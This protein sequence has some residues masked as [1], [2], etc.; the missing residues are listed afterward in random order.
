VFRHVLAELRTRVRANKFV[1]TAH[2][3]DEAEEDGLSVYD[4]EHIILTGEILARQIDAD[5]H[6]R[7]YVVG[8]KSISGQ[9]CEVVVK[10]GLSEKIV[11]ITAYVL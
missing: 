1:M 3:L 5:T 9:G 8:G 10:F 11:I 2:A 4:V 7:K 6:E